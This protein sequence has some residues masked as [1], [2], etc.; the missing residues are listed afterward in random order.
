MPGPVSRT[1]TKN[2][3]LFGF[4][5]DDDFP[6][7]G[8]LNCVADEINQNLGQT[9]AVT[10]ARRGSGAIPALTAKTR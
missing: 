1:D 3:S 6:R 8:E 2:A 9:A 10:V 5:L 7:I 4:R